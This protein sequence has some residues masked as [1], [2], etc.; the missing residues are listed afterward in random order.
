MRVPLDVRPRRAPREPGKAAVPPD[1][2]APDTW[3]RAAGGHCVLAR[4][5][6]WREGAGAP[7]LGFQPKGVVRPC[8]QPTR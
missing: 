5:P 3:V 2:P 1:L 4:C 8:I 6:R 7:I